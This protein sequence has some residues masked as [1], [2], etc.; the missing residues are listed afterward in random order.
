MP[1]R[2][3]KAAVDAV[4]ERLLH[5][6]PSLSQSAAL[7]AARELILD[8]RGGCESDDDWKHMW[9]DK[10]EITDLLESWI[11]MKKARVH[12]D[13]KS[14]ADEPEHKLPDQQDEPEHK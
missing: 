9:S 10:D 14:T 8:S 6:D 12:E 1:P 7:K 2:V 5:D 11:P 13:P 3:A 4:M